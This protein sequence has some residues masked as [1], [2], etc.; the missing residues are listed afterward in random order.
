MLFDWVYGLFSNDLA[1][2]RV[3]HAQRTAIVIR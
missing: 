1:P 2:I 3:A